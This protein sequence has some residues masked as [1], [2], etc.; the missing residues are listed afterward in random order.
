MTLKRREMLIG[1][2]FIMPFMIGFLIFYLIP[3]VISVIYSFTSGIG[4]MEM[5]GLQNYQNV[6]KSYAFQ[7][8]A[9][10]T[11]RFMGIGIPLLIFVSL[12]ISL[13]IQPSF[14]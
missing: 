9:K 10:N 5:A 13:L 3:F 12:S 2:A 4:G 6:F 11:F 14:V 8:A 7:L 1:M